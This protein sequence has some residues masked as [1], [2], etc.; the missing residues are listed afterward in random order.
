MFFQKKATFD[1]FIAGL[2]NPGFQYEHTRH[3]VGFMAVDRLAQKHGASITRLKEKAL[4]GEVKIGE[5]RVLLAKPQT[6]MNLS[7][8]SVSALCKFYKIPPERV[9]ILLDDISLPV[10]KIR[11]RARGSSGGHNGLKNIALYLGEGYP[12]V[13]VGVGDKPRP[14]YDLAKWV[15]SNFPKEDQKALDES[16]D[17]A[18]AA[19]ELMAEG[20]IQEAM[21]RYNG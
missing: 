16:L 10:G 9:I 18:V 15:L 11:V 6:F 2:G 13:R 3:N 17:K 19:V 12:R 7:G 14:D 5:S 1:Y 8:E 4:T 21:N 20:N